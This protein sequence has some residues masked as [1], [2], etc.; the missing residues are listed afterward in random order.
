MESGDCTA[1]LQEQVASATEQAPLRVAGGGSK[2]FL[3]PSWDGAI[4]D[5]SRHRGMVAYEPGELVLTAR[6]GTPMREIRALLREQGQ[7]LPFEPPGYGEDAT[8]GGTIAGNLSG[9]RRAYAGAARDFVLGCRILNGQAQ[10]LR[11]GGEVIK[12]VAGYDASRLMVG[13]MGTLGVLLDISCKV[14]PAPEADVTRIFETGP[15]DAVALMR[16]WATQ[17]LPVSATCYLD[18]RLWV[19]LSGSGDGVREGA[20]AIGGEAFAEDADFWRSLREQRHAFFQ[21]RRPLWRLSVK[22]TVAPAP[23]QL[24]EWG[25]ALRWWK[26]DLA[27]DAV[28]R[29]AEEQGGYARLWR[30]SGGDAARLPSPSGPRGRIQRELKRAFDPRGVLNPGCLYPDW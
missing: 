3:V 30:T 13:A 24:I 15:A 17:P 21:T 23:D 26:T 19:R 2:A 28:H 10:V 16:R 4:L 1:E 25:G 14:L 9:P 6:A 7:M 20:R 5:V 11:F 29:A 12:N 8:L 27:A 18:G 22:P